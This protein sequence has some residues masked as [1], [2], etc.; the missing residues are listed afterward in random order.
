MADVTPANKNT[1]K[2]NINNYRSVSI[3]PTLSKICERC[4]YG[5]T[6]TYFDPILSN[7]RCNFQKGNST[8]SCLLAMIEKW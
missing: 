3:F 1:N 5:Q 4:S 2:T 6:Y 7:S 8:P